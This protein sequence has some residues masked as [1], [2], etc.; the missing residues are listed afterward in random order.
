MET[1]RRALLVAHHQCSD[2]YCTFCDFL[3]PQLTW[4][5][6][7]QVRI[8]VLLITPCHRHVDTLSG[9]QLYINIKQDKPKSSVLSIADK[10]QEGPTKSRSRVFEGFR[11]TIFNT[12]FTILL[13][14]PF[15]IGGQVSRKVRQSPGLESSKGSERLPV[16]SSFTPSA[17][18][19]PISTEVR[20]SPG[21][22]SSK[23]P[24]RGS[25]TPHTQRMEAN[26][27]QTA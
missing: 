22:E 4:L 18:R 25:A 8:T 6:T 5:C 7:W 27:A 2:S 24:E 19:R 16:F 23:G 11:K 20:Q 17:V 1:A 3:K 21:L 10:S 9:W 26:R 15:S 13:G 12:K 14:A